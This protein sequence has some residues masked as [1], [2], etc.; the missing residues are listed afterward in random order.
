MCSKY[1][2]GVGGLDW[3]CSGLEEFSAVGSGGQLCLSSSAGK[4]G[5]CG[6]QCAVS[7]KLV[8]ECLVLSHLYSTVT[9]Y[10]D[11]G[12]QPNHLP[13]LHHGPA[14]GPVTPAAPWAWVF[15]AFVADTLSVDGNMNYAAQDRQH[16]PQALLIW[17]AVSSMTLQASAGAKRTEH[18]RCANRDPC[19]SQGVR[20]LFRIGIF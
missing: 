10:A 20:L 12:Q 11:S 8:T 6:L 15:G 14:T 19:C 4:M 17:Y 13:L 7:C 2:G 3:T 16:F 5:E 9:P 18:E 1:V